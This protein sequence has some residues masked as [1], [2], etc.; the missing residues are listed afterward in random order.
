AENLL[1]TIE[2]EL[3]RSSKGDAVRLEVEADCPKDFIELL[4]GFYDL[5]EAD[6]YKLDG[7]LSMTHL[8]PLL[9]NDAFANLKDR[10]YQPVLDPALSPHADIFEVLRHQDVL[11]HHPY[12]SFEPIVDLMEEAARDP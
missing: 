7:P 10:P 2:V 11:L 8:P 3:R 6:V 4:T 9:T 5:T 1:R 12:D